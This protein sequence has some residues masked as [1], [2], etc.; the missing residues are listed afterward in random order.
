MQ[1]KAIKSSQEEASVR[2]Q[3]LE[4]VLFLLDKTFKRGIERIGSK[5][6][7]LPFA[8]LQNIGLESYQ[9]HLEILF[10]LLNFQ[11]SQGGGPDPLRLRRDAMDFI[12]EALK[13]RIV[14]LIEKYTG[15]SVSGGRKKHKNEFENV[16]ERKKT[17]TEALN[18]QQ[19]RFNEGS[20]DEIGDNYD[21][22]E[23]GKYSE[24][25]IKDILYPNDNF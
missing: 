10:S 23:A 14:D 22:N 25:E 16:F 13:N 9:G 1:M 15:S 18:R 4:K 3:S 2:G 20:D 11:Q 5:I 8:E 21:D 24:K 19:N 12:L 6:L 7:S 17:L